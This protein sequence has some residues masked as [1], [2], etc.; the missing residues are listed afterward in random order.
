MREQRCAGAIL[1]VF[2][3]LGL[4]VQAAPPAG[5]AGIRLEKAAPAAAATTASA[6]TLVVPYLTPSPAI[7]G[8]LSDLKIPPVV[9]LGKSRLFLGWDPD[10]LYVG[11]FVSDG[12][13][14][15]TSQSDTTS[16]DAAILTVGNAELFLSSSR[17]NRPIYKRFKAGELER[18][19]YHRR[20]GPEGSEVAVQRAEEKNEVAY[21]LKV[22]WLTLSGALPA[23]EAGLP[24]RFRLRDR[25]SDVVKD[26]EF[27]PAGA[28]GR[29]LV[30][31]LGPPALGTI[32]ARLA[33]GKDVVLPGQ[34]PEV[35]V[36]FHRA[37]AGPLS[38]V[39]VTL[40]GAPVFAGD[41]TLEANRTLFR[42]KGLSL[43]AGL[44]RL[45]V[46]LGGKPAAHLSLVA[47]DVPAA[48]A[49]LTALRKRLEA[50]PAR[51]WSA[52]AGRSL[53]RAQRLA[54]DVEAN[55]GAR[56]PT[57][58]LAARVLADLD[59]LE[60][61][62]A[63]LE[64]GHPAY[65]GRTG[66]LRCAYRSK[67]DGSL[68]PYSLYVPKGGAAGAPKP[69]L[70]VLS[71]RNEDESAC[72]EQTDLAAVAE[73]RGTIVLAPHGRG[74]EAIYRGPAALD[75]EEAIADVRELNAVDASRIGI[76]GVEA[77]GTAALELALQRPDLFR[78]VG[79]VNAE[80]DQVAAWTHEWR[81]E[82]VQWLAGVLDSRSALAHTRNATRMALYLAYQSGNAQL[83][84]QA[85]KLARSLK[86]EKARYQITELAAGAGALASF[87]EPMMAFLDAAPPVDTGGKLTFLTTR[88]S[89]NSAWWTRIDAVR[90]VGFPASI[91]AERSSEGLFKVEVENTTA[92]SLSVEGTSS[93]TGSNVEVGIDA[94][95]VQA[96]VGPDGWVRL[97]QEGSKWAAGPMV[98][99][100]SPRKSPAVEGPI[101]QAFVSPFLFVYG[102]TGPDAA[103]CESAARESARIWEQRFNGQ[104]EARA[105][106]KVTTGDE[107]ARNL[108]LFATPASSKRL[109]ELLSSVAVRVTTAGVQVGKSRFEGKVIGIQVVAPNPRR[110][111]RYAVAVTG[112]TPAALKL[113]VGHDWRK[114]DYIVVDPNYREDS[115][116]SVMGAGS[117]DMTWQP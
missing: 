97:H 2:L 12:S 69:L 16:T 108:I 100:T 44:H 19:L 13:L 1:A 111:D 73:K 17:G 90:A 9:E 14:V 106:S 62:V 115:P 25:I 88:L 41:L 78:G 89:R 74:L 98:P 68:Q 91:Q 104:A 31:V 10:D 37:D 15:S 56:L 4:R 36:S 103:Q 11:V 54:A 24:F 38:A 53:A 67:L 92:L 109:P 26:S 46:V 113:L 77:G 58:M 55:L 30:L 51:R 29:P 70:V 64:A 116:S 60:K 110:P 8:E 84:E 107:S 63:Q 76:A 28:A 3:L 93:K 20:H 18:N 50:W 83:K 87:W 57:S 101:E 66:L 79:A 81:K 27:V 43:P 33:A 42:L 52:P 32:M 95:Q 80:P 5:G 48:Q 23:A 40:D 22:P 96:P 45:E 47:L 35:H 82:P 72:F 105:E 75:V 85:T 49:K 39:Q 117:F 59:D 21:E 34:D 65:E 94:G 71:D 99:A 61:A 112:N 86:D 114:P 102:D 7:D 6:F